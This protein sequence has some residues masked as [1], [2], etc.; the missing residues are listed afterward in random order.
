[1]WL[2][3]YFFR[4]CKCFVNMI[5]FEADFCSNHD[6]TNHW[7][8][9]SSPLLSFCS[10][11]TQ[12]CR[13]RAEMPYFLFKAEET[14]LFNCCVTFCHKLLRGKICF[15]TFAMN[16]GNFQEVK[17]TWKWTVFSNCNW[18]GPT[19]RN[20]VKRHQLLQSEQPNIQ[21]KIQATKAQH[22]TMYLHP[23]NRNSVSSSWV[24]IWCL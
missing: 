18:K 17:M 6:W 20:A 16:F 14:L 5:I 15:V 24:L 21:T 9:S 19:K 10:F 11:I 12:F 7:E 22:K 13:F 1:M 23:P 8:P 3:L 2:Y 4:I